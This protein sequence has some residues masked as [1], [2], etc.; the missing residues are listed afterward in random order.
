MSKG[1]II[2]SQMY[3]CYRNL[4]VCILY[5]IIYINFAAVHRAGK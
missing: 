4:H 5:I 2:I 1:L 3:I